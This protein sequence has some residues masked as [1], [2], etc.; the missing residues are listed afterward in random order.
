M[1]GPGSGAWT[2]LFFVSHRVDN[3]MTLG[4]TPCHS[5]CFE[6]VSKVS[7][8]PI[9]FSSGCLIVVFLSLHFLLLTLRF[10]VNQRVDYWQ[11]PCHSCCFEVVGKVSFDPIGFSS[12][13]LI[14]MFPSTLL[15]FVNHGVSCAP[16]LANVLPFLL[17]KSCRQGEL[18][19]IG[20]SSVCLIVVSLSLLFLLLTPSFLC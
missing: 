6:V 15:I 19:P 2:L 14:V 17:S 10:F 18:G 5:C 9:G 16:T 12:G 13:C 8:D 3:D 7:F 4:Q 1:V 11:T 20:F